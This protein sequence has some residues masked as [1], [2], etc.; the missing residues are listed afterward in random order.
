MAQAVNSLSKF[1]SQNVQAIHGGKGK[2]SI[3]TRTTEIG[4]RSGLLLSSVLAASQVSDSR[5]ELLKSKMSFIF[6]VSLF[7]T[8]FNLLSFLVKA[9]LPII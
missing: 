6:Y 8:S 5:T 1:A 3:T 7:I 4:R 2:G 9:V